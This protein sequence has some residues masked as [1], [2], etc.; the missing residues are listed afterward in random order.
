MRRPGLSSYLYGWPVFPGSGGRP[1]RMST[2]A[3]VRGPCYTETLTMRA[4]M[5]EDE[6]HGYAA[7]DGLSAR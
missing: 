2:P 4:L 6:V 5:T 7:A 3:K 1:M